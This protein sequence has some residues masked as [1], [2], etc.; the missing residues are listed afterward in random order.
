MKRVDIYAVKWWEA[1]LKIVS[2]IIHECI[3]SMLRLCSVMKKKKTRSIWILVFLNY[4]ENW[5]NIF[6]E[7]QQNI[8]NPAAI[9]SFLAIHSGEILRIYLRVNINIL[10]KF[11]NAFLVIKIKN[12]W[13][14]IKEYI[15]HD[16]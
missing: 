5:I 16:I 3:T 9:Y 15:I 7:K 1:M 11:Q 10:L 12:T 6:C 13:K 4:L 8:K 2:E 14:Q